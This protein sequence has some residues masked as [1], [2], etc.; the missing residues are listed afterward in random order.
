MKH[1]LQKTKVGYIAQRNGRPQFVVE[2]CPEQLKHE[3]GNV[4]V[5]AP[6]REISPAEAALMALKDLIKGD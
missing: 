5:L 1:Q 6:V 2:R 4:I 3:L